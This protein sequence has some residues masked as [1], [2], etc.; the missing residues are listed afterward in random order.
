MIKSRSDFIIYL[1]ADRKALARQNNW[2]LKSRMFDGIWY[3]ERLL[4]KIEYFQN[5]KKGLFWKIIRQFY[6]LKFN[7]LSQELGFS[8]PINVFGPGLSIAH[9]GTI[10]INPEV[11]IGA[12]CRLHVCV[13]IGVGSDGRCPV[14]GDNCYIGP[15]AKLFGGIKIANG[16][17][18]GANAVVN[19]SFLEENCTIAGVPAKVV[20]KR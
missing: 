2:S 18:I 17:K 5:C 16:I 14:L 20:S 10:V 15:G 11:K 6:V 8:I 1:E 7:K 3:F 13:N 12:N 9:R 19:K 4:R